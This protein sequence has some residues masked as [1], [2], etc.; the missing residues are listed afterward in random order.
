MMIRDY[1]ES[2]FERISEIY[3]LSKP[4]EFSRE[5]ADFITTPLSGD[6]PMLAF[7]LNLK[8]LSMNHKIL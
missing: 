5:L 1:K 6:E 4:D 7:F 2:D 3:D 8:S